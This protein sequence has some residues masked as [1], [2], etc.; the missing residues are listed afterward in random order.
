MITEERTIVGMVSGK[1]MDSFEIEN[2]GSGSVVEHLL[3]KEKVAGSVPVS[4]SNLSRQ[5]EA[6][7][8]SLPG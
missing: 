8:V 4:R 7:K 2:C 3:A 5:R 1:D 6:D